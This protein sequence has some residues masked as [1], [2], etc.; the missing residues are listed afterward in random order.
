MRDRVF[1]EFSV[2]EAR[3]DIHHVNMLALVA[4]SNL[5]FEAGQEG[6]ASEWLAKVKTVFT[7]YSSSALGIELT[8]TDTQEMEMADAY[9]KFVKGLRP[10]LSKDSKHGGLVV[11]GLD[12]LFLA[13][14][15]KPPL[16][17]E[18][19]KEQKQDTKK[20]EPA[21]TKKLRTNLRPD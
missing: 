7:N 12:K 13:H 6:K 14:G 20:P 10:K 4:S 15:E 18:P 16:P 11:T 2:R 21:K 19:E 9:G 1:R 8:Q 17:S 5:R 3:K